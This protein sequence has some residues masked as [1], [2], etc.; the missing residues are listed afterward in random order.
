MD[1]LKKA[2][3]TLIL[4]KFLR[5]RMSHKVLSNSCDPLRENMVWEDSLEPT[6]KHCIKGDIQWV[7]YTCG[8]GGRM[9]RP[10]VVTV[11]C[12]KI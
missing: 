7:H 10:T 11:A 5:G 8:E 1:R 2:A 12:V 4:Y 9:A 6:L 3:E